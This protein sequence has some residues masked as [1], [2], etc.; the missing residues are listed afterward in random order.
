MLRL[1]RLYRSFCVFMRVCFNIGKW[2]YLLSVFSFLPHR[3]WGNRS[4]FVRVVLRQIP[5]HSLFLHRHRND[6]CAGRSDLGYDTL[7]RRQN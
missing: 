5:K 6:C 7:D 1:V 2:V 4:S 3:D